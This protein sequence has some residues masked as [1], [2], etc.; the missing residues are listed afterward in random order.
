MAAVD[1]EME[2]VCHHREATMSNFS[3]RGQL[4]CALSIAFCTLLTAPGCRRSE[5]ISMA[6]KITLDGDVLPTGSISM[7]P[8]ERGPSVGSEI[9]EG[10]YNISADHGPLRGAKYRIE[11]RS[12]DVSSG[13][14]KHPLSGGVY[15]VYEDRVPLAYNSESQLELSIPEDADDLLQKDFELQSRPGK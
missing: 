9:V 10:D 11:I 4:L 7:I 15:P 13:S 14:T 8:L 6:G 5:K 2:K 1:Q 12:L 3:R